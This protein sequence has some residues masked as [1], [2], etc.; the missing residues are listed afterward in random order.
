[1]PDIYIDVNGLELKPLAIAD[2]D[3]QIVIERDISFKE[4]LLAL[5]NYIQ[6]G[7]KYTKFPDDSVIRVEV[8]KD[9]LTLK[10]QSLIHVK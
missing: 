7:L 2:F 9:S 10:Q 3:K 4:A 6:K 1:M 5:Q 8:G